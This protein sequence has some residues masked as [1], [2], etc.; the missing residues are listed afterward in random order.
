M[1]EIQTQFFLCKC[2]GAGAVIVVA[3]FDN[4]TEAELEMENA[5]KHVNPRHFIME[6]LA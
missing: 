3:Q 1:T 5:N 6:V 4:L 2:D